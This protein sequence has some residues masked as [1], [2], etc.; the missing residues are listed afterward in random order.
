MGM[1]LAKESASPPTNIVHHICS[2][3]ENAR[4]AQVGINSTSIKHTVLPF[5]AETPHKNQLTLF[6]PD[7]IWDTAL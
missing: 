3:K 7:A 6:V 1:N 4:N 5:D 2:K